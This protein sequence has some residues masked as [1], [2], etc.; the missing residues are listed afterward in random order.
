MSTHIA[1]RSSRARAGPP[2]SRPSRHRPRIGRGPRV[3]VSRDPRWRRSSTALHA[4]GARELSDDRGRLVAAVAFDAAGML[5]HPVPLPTCSECTRPS[6]EPSAGAILVASNAIN[7]SRRLRSWSRF[8]SRGR[9]VHRHLDR[10]TVRRCVRL[11]VIALDHGRARGSGRAS[12]FIAG[13]VDAAAPP[14][15][16]K[17]SNDTQSVAAPVGRRSLPALEAVVRF[18]PLRAWAMVQPARPS[19]YHLLLTTA[20]RNN[21]S[22]ATLPYRSSPRRAPRGQLVPGPA[23]ASRVRRRTTLVC[24]R[25]SEAVTCSM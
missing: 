23:E 16:R 21:L 15:A 20:S 1:P 19:R 11:R 17:L 9:R 5:P 2:R 13:S 8:L 18:G 25:A 4:D 3:A 24:A 14:I 10:C 22:E 6:G 7:N 12:H